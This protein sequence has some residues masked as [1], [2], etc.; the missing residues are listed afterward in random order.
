[1]VMSFIP[2]SGAYLG[3]GLI[4][5]EIL[6]KYLSFVKLINGQIKASFNQLESSIK[7]R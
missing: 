3:I 4:M 2:R 5:L 6:S 1:M 7:F